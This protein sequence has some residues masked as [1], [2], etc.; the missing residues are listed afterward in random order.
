M[1]FL[2]LILLFLQT[3]LSHPDEGL[4]IKKLVRKHGYPIESHRFETPDGYLLKAYRIPHGKSGIPSKRVALLVHGCGGT[5]ENFI[6]L[7]PP[8]AMVFYMADRGYDVWLFNARGNRHSRKHR[9]L[10][11]NRNAKKFW[12]FSF[13]EIGIYDLPTTIEYV[14]NYTKAKKLFY[15]GHS[16]GGTSF[17]IMLSERPELNKKI[18][19][20][21]LLAPASHLEYTLTPMF[22]S[23][24]RMIRM[25]KVNN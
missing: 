23:F 20:A 12:N 13:H 1:E 2:V 5:A 14:L 17:Y 7:G 4:S 15:V 19:A 25:I 16:Q 8:N 9:T 11:P 3:V 22:F 10:S 21:A 18:S 6:V 24:A